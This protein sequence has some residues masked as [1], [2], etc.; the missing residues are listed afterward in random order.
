MNIGDLRRY[1]RLLLPSPI[2][3]YLDGAADD[4]VSK[5]R[6]CSDF[7]RYELLPRFLVDISAIDTSTKLMQEDLSF[8]VICS[9]TGMSRLFH[10]TGELAVA[11]ACRKMG[12][13]YSLSTLSTYSIE[14]V[15]SASAGSKWFQIYVF[16]DRG[17]IT[18]FMQRCRESGFKALVLTIDV[19]TQGNRERDVRTGMTVPPRI[20]IS[21][22]FRFVLSPLWS[23]NYLF[24]KDFQL[25]NVAHKAPV[26]SSDLKTLVDYLHEQFDPSVTWKDAAGMVEEWGGA[27]SVKGIS[28]VSD[29]LKAVEIGATSLILSN[30]GGRQLDHTISPISLLPEVRKAVGDDVEIIIDGGVRRGTDIFKA[31]ALGA[32]ACSLGRSC[33]YGLA[34]G[35]EKGVTKSLEILRDEFRRT[36]A[37]M[38]GTR[39]D[40]IDES[41]LRNRKWR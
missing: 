36:M 26:D 22:A 16:K 13:L 1:S 41:C 17:L 30:H 7:N 10:E 14:E 29:A 9:P 18:E 2:F 6:N 35:G 19:P 11:E 3:G 5:S 27:F 34:V 28:S 21:S 15:A 33:L 40:Q 31:I 24:A 32:T 20:N 39:V 37:L 8:P 12:I 4:E 23:L 38:G 25:A